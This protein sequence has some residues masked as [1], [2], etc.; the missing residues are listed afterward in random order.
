M[1]D[2][3]ITIHIDDTQESW[4]ARC[5]R[6]IQ[7]AI[8]ELQGV[9]LAVTTTFNP[10]NS[11]DITQFR[12]LVEQRQ[13]VLGWIALDGT[14]SAPLTVS[15]APPENLT[16]FI[17]HIDGN[18]ASLGELLA[19]TDKAQTPEQAREW[20]S[21]EIYATTD[22]SAGMLIDWQPLK[23]D[24]SAWHTFDAISFKRF[25]LRRHADAWKLIHV[26]AE[27]SWPREDL[28]GARDW[29]TRTAR[30]RADTRIISWV[31]GPTTTEGCTTLHGAGT[32][33]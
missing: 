28:T 12:H 18:H 1:D 11:I 25:I 26:T 21:G 23:D 19:T 31:P 27:T 30:V 5:T 13:T 29:A 8:T 10:A 17:L 9:V 14:I 15:Q 4:A 24:N 20:A 16:T 7:D 2:D 32:P 3:L 33:R 22:V 6:P